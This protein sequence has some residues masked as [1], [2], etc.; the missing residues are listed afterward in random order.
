MDA[1]V[2]RFPRRFRWRVIKN[3][4]LISLVAAAAAFGSSYYRMAGFLEEDRHA[5]G[6]LLGQTLAEGSEPGL[7]ARDPALLKGPLDRLFRAPDLILAEIYQVDGARLA[8]RSR[9]EAGDSKA[10]TKDLVTK[11]LGAR[12]PMTVVVDGKRRDEYFSPVLVRESEAPAGDAVGSPT[13]TGDC[14]AIGFVRV[15]IGHGQ[16]EARQRETLLG[17][18][19]LGLGLLGFGL[20]LAVL[21]GWRLSDPILKLASGADAIRHGDLDVRVDIRSHDE[22]GQLAD[23]INRMVWRL[24]LNVDQLADLNRNLESQVAARTQ[25]IRGMAAFLEILNARRDL[26]SLARDA[27]GALLQGIPGAIGAIYVFDERAAS[28]TLQVAQ[29]V[30]RE[31]FGALTVPIGEDLVGVAAKESAPLVLTEEPQLQRLSSALG[32]RLHT[33]L[34]L[35]ILFA[36]SLAG[37]LVVGSTE[38][39]GSARREALERATHPLAVAIANARAFGAAELLARELEGRNVALTR[40]TELLEEQKAKLEEMNRLKGELMANITHELRTPLDAVIGYAELMQGGAYGE[41]NDEQAENTGAIVESARGL[42]NLINQI[43]DMAKMEAGQM[44]LVISEVDCCAILR[45]S[46]QTAQVLARGRP[47][48]VGLG[49]PEAPLVL[50]TDEGKLRQIVTNLVSNAVKFTEQGR[51][52]LLCAREPSGAVRVVVRDTGIG[53]AE[54]HLGII[55]TEFRQVDGSTTRAA[56]GTGLGLAISRRFARLMGGDITVESTPGKGSTFTVHLPARSPEAAVDARAE[57]QRLD[58]VSQTLGLAGGGAATRDSAAGDRG[59]TEQ[60]ITLLE[61]GLSSD[62]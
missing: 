57:A 47:I 22:L 55:F 25:D 58:D 56:M 37:V 32:E 7:R 40:Q 44:A 39:I 45:E 8:K 24:K 4:L 23:S 11:L 33:V 54:E 60:K 29:G 2:P 18:I 14:R 61:D 5:R 51:V 50:W 1:T 62:S 28:L 27:L 42:L 52:E 31:A 26:G 41:L 46:A 9:D 15:V 36:D 16:Q 19:Y 20:L 49:L 34:F 38:E 53:I 12:E 3:I 21:V 17:S 43:L 48:R 59:I 6:G 35:R 30:P 13:A 10:P